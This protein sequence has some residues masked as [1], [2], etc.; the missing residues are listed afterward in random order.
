MTIINYN[1]EKSI[2]EQSNIFVALY[3]SEKT[4]AAGWSLE[5]LMNCW[6]A[7]HNEVVYVSAS[8]SDCSE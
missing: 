7:K 4:L 3:D 8:R 5:R 1:P 2:A 6:G